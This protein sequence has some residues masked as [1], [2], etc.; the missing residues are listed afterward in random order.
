MKKLLSTWANGLTTFSIKPL[1]IATVCGI[2]MAMIGF[3][4]I[5]GLVILKLTRNNIAL[6]WTSMI[7]TTILIGGMIMMMLGVIG[8][9]VGRIYLTLNENPQYVIRTI[10][11]NTGKEDE[12]K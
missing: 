6:G 5:I 9:Y 3:L 2:F 12:G 7:A 8:E 11:D 4:I 1:R 10:I